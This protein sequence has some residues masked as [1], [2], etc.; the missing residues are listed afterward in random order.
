MDDSRKERLAAN[1]SALPARLSFWM[2][3]AGGALGAIWQQMPLEQQ[4]ALVEHSWLPAWA[5]P[6]ALTVAGIVSQL[7]PRKHTVSP[8]E[9]ATPEVLLVE[10]DRSE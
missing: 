3:G 5:Y 6:I 10:K 9:A 1:F 7:W 4:K 8:D 2:M